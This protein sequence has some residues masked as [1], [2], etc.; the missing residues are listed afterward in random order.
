MKRVTKAQAIGRITLRSRYDY[1]AISTLGIA[2]SVSL[3]F[4]RLNWL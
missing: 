2:E 3:V 1:L 4:L